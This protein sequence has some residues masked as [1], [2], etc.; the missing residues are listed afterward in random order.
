MESFLENVQKLSL[1][2]VPLD[3]F[4]QGGLLYRQAVS[5]LAYA[6]MCFPDHPVVKDLEQR[7]GRAHSLLYQAERSKARNW[8]VFWLETWPAQVRKA[9]C[10]ILLA[11]GVFWIATVVGFL[12]TMT[13]PVLEH[14]FVNPDMRR[15]IE[16][17]RLWTESLT[18]TA[19]RESAGIAVHNIQVCLLTWAL[20]LTFGIGT[21]WLMVLNGL[22]LGSLS[23]ACLR[24]ACWFR[25]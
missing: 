4:R 21:I 9:R 8:R 11:T 16:A 23:A 18:G 25:S 15:A 24:L 19:P 10:P 3:A 1:A 22:M 12:L 6:R 13:N 14:Y 7:V 20:G 17:K 2:R 5:D